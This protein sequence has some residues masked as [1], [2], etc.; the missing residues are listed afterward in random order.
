M[1]E[2]NEHQIRETATLQF[3]RWVVRH[4]FWVAMFLVIATLFFLYPT[5]NA[6]SSGF[7]YELPGPIV[8]VDASARAQWPDHPFIHA[9]DKFSKDFGSSSIIAIAVVVKEGTIFTP[10]TLKKLQRITHR[11]DGEG[12]DSRTD[13][14]Q[15]ERDRIEEMLPEDEEIDTFALIKKLDRKF[16]PYPVNH[17]RVQALTHSSTR[18]V[19][20]EPDGAITSEVL[21]S[22][23]PKTQAE[24]D[25]VREK[26]RQNPPF[27]FG[28]LVSLDEK[29]A[30]LAANF[31]TDRLSGREVYM[32][33]FDH[34]QKI[35]NGW[36]CGELEIAEGMECSEGEWIWEPEEDENHQIFISGE[37]IGAGWIIKHAFEIGVF[38]IAT[39]TLTFLLLLIYFRRL[40]GV[41][42]PFIA[43]IA[44]AIWGLGFTGWMQITFDPLVLVI[45][46]IITA[47]A[48]SHT[49]QMAERFFEDF[50]ALMPVYDN[51]AE[52]AK[53]E[54]ATVA[55][56]E[57]IVPGTLGIV[58]DF[59]GLLVILITS[60]PQ[61]RDLAFF[62]AFWVFTILFTVEILHPI[63][64]CYLAP[65]HDSEHYL[66]GFMIRLMRAIGR[67]V[68]GPVSKYAVAGVAVGLLTASS[69]IAFTQ[70]KIGE[71]SPGTPLLWP[72]HEF[73]MATAE[74]ADRFGGVDSFVIYAD[75]DR[76]KAT[77]DP[78]PIHKIENFERWMGANTKLGMPVS[79]VPIIRAYWR[80]NHYGDPKWYFIPNHPGT[81]R[82]VIFQLRQNGSPG[83]LRPYA[84]DDDRRATVNFFYPDHKGDTISQAVVAA[85]EFIRR[86]PIGEVNIR[87]EMD[88][89]DR[90][91][92]FFDYDKM[93]DN[94]YYMIG[95]MLPPRAHTMRVSIRHS[96]G[97]YDYIDVPPSE[98]TPEWIEEFADDAMG[99]F[100]DARD[101]VEEGEYFA[102]PA[103]LEEWDASHIDAIYENEELGIRAVAMKTKNLIVHDLKAVDSVPKY[104]P[105]NSWTRGVQ[106]VMAG[107]VMGV[108]AAVNDEVERGHIANISLILLV[109]YILQTLTYRSLWSGT[110]IVIQ[111]ATATMLSLAYMSIKG[112]GLNINTLP[113]Q[114]VGV[115]IGVDYAIYIVDRIRQEVVD[116]KGDIDEAV[117]R[118]ISTTGMAVSFTATTIVGG[119]ATWMASNLRFQAEMAQLLVIL[120][121]INMLGAITVVPALYSIIK[122]KFAQRLLEQQQAERAGA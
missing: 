21:I 72:D 96:D 114:S 9:Q 44:T 35:K 66:P 106:F 46:M 36:K 100:E 52:K 37:P 119:I 26:V 39:V 112:V 81:V 34:V 45:P 53:I 65:P 12:Y 88:R 8:R 11:L 116:T 95:P 85:R 92:G 118:T 103:D 10:E 75:G 19:T 110:I 47:R 83:F 33:V 109:I 107:G 59:L 69:Y 27:I 120:M 6:V 70:S 104:Q 87:L 14:R 63:M 78:E 113:V 28:R 101:D 7:G 41:L 40:H 117:R 82:N 43:A 42:I 55:M 25:E 20:I 121:V 105:T 60:I 13:E 115:G 108:L 23:V 56:G 67:F 57:L 97:S 79:I 5:V 80:Q 61:M 24:A 89:A 18:V 31:I 74:I 1:A 77:A 38:V 99:D 73:N 76:D 32:A 111:L 51:N 30:F 62:G 50:E 15:D 68:T 122:P 102:W 90:D 4:R 64:I 54:A 93:A 17:D 98:E 84:T 91:A 71:A 2:G 3:A 86:N 16:P 94:T 58:T 29:A 22:E 48:V 49:V